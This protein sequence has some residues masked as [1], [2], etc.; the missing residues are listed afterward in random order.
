MRK[1]NQSRERKGRGERL[2]GD[3]KKKDQRVRGE[4][5]EQE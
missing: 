1:K 2:T 5:N 3:R 4:R